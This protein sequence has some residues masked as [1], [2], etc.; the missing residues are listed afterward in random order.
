MLD[1]IM[2]PNGFRGRDDG[3]LRQIADEPRTVTINWV[4]E[5]CGHLGSGPGLNSNCG[6]FVED[7]SEM[8]RNDVAMFNTRR[9][10]KKIE[11]AKPRRPVFHDAMYRLVAE[12]HI[13]SRG[14]VAQGRGLSGPVEISTLNG[15]DETIDFDC[16]RS[17]R[18]S[19]LCRGFREPWRS[20][21]S[22]G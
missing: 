22:Q 20:P 5:N 14:H 3:N 7:R 11:E 13:D 12:V 19:P 16:R 6:R 15:P 17:W 10:S 9:V 18:A 4:A 8:R 1:E 2:S 21:L